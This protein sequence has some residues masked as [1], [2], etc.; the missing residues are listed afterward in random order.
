MICGIWCVERAYQRRECSLASSTWADHEEGGRV[1]RRGG[2]L[3]QKGME[4]YGQAKR[5]NDGEEDGA[6]VGGEG[7]CEPAVL[8]V[9]RHSV[10]RCGGILTQRRTGRW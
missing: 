10:R 9:P 2:L 3:I 7:R 5:D 6:Q 1:G 4:E 8:I